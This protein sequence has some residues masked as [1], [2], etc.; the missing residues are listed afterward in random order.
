MTPKVTAKKS[1][2]Q[3]FL[4]NQGVL[5]RIIEAGEVSPG[6]TVLEIGPGTGALTRALAAT[7]AT[8][9]ALEKDARLIGPLTEEFKDMPNVRIIEGDALM[10]DT[11][12]LG[13]QPGLWKL[14]ANIPYYLTSHL[15]RLALERWRPA[16]AVLMVQREVAGRITAKPPEMNLLAL[17]VQLYAQPSRVM[18]VSRGS[19]RPVPDVDSAVIRFDVFPDA[20][21]DLNERVMKVAKIAFARKR[22]QLKMGPRP[23][24]R[25]QELSVEDWKKLA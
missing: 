13:L 5:A 9:I 3:N 7:G 18:N 11:G 17:S 2:G 12:E 10:L 6:D 22:K 8:V 21:R 14:V 19:F 15:I 25:P 4:V 20:D 16:N 23:S 24:A 1:L